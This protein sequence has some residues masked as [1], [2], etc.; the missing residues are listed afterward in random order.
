M[1]RMPALAGPA[2]LPG[3]PGRDPTVGVRETSNDAGQ[4]IENQTVSHR[5][6]ATP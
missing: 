5:V 3:L 2:R 6:P 1:E 4:T